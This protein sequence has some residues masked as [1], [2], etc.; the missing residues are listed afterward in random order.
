M[1]MQAKMRQTRRK[2]SSAIPEEIA[3]FDALAPDWWSETGAMRALHRMNPARLEFIRHCLAELCPPNAAPF[4][5]LAGLRILDI[6]CGGGILAEPLARMGAQV[7]GIDAAEAAIRTARAHARRQGLAIDYRRAQAED[8]SAAGEDF[9]AVCAL[10]IIEHVADP[11]TFI[12]DAARL[13]R[14]GG[15]IILS[16]LNRTANSFF[17]GVV[18]AEYILGWAPRGTH[19]WRKFLRPSELTHMLRRNGCAVA[20]L[21]GIVFDPI[22]G[23]F[24]L[25]P[26]DLGINYL[27]AARKPV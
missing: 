16:T 19:D 7:T 3:H 2:T 22:A 25:H 27:L 15:A 14:P 6:G 5:P 17:L 23:G 13:V 24:R 8:L 4:Q 12:H 11:E 21:S 20:R 18:A 9:D 26:D 10:E 1:P